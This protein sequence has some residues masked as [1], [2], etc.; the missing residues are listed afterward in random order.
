M[1]WPKPKSLLWT[2]AGVFLLV[3]VVATI[4]Q[5][6]FVVTILRPVADRLRES[7]LQRLA[8]TAA[9]EISESF[10]DPTP[11]EIREKLIQVER[12]ERG[13]ELIFRRTDGEIIGAHPSPIDR[14]RLPPPPRGTNEDTT[15]S[16]RWR[17]RWT[18]FESNS[19]LLTGAY[20]VETS[21]G[22]IGEVI[23]ITPRRG[24]IPRLEHS[25]WHVLLVLPISIVLAGVGGFALFRYLLRRIRALE[26][27]ALQVAE[28]DL[29]VRVQHSGRDEIDRVGEQLNRMTERLA[30]SRDRVEQMD[31][32]R[33]QLLADISHELST[34]LTSIRGY[35]ETLSNP[36][37]PLSDEERRQ[38]L[39][40][41]LDESERM[42]LLVNDL[43]ELARL[44]SGSAG[45]NTERL[46][47]AAL[48]RNIIERYRPK[49]E[50]AGLH[51]EAPPADQEAWLTADG[52]RLEQ[53]F[54]NLLTNALRYVPSGG[55]VF[56]TLDTAVPGHHRLTVADDGPGFSDEDLPYVFD[57]FYRADP[58]RS[59]SG[60]GLGLAIV[61]EI[62][63]QHG[64]SVSASNREPSGAVITI[65]LPNS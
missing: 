41:I 7:S 46:D 38:Y 29:S 36:E 55:T 27:L 45:L 3:L 13:I 64:G 57:R 47:W 60:T 42:G 40:N 2:L 4:V 51:I 50:R 58:A 61:K 54:E 15:R 39:A 14:F 16:R 31:R 8:R 26:H 5:A 22:L 43:L 24:N 48:C 21:L 28:G 52:R 44:E 17:R 25:P 34:P 32:Q 35:A 37:M 6:V 53:M 9:L 30:Q 65:Q 19:R 18:A 12:G 62:A 20:P 10:T 1:N 63:Q 49:F 23:A 11:D 59:D 33:R 56:V